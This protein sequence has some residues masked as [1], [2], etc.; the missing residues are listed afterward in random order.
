MSVQRVREE[1]KKAILKLI[2]ALKGLTPRV[3]EVAGGQEEYR[4]PGASAAYPYGE[5]YP[6]SERGLQGFRRTRE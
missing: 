2:E 1:Q 6:A 4:I 5:A 3:E